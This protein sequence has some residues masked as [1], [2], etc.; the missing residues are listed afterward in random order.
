MIGAAANRDPRA[1][2]DA[3]KFDIDRDRTEAQNLGLG[4]GIH[5]CLGAALCL[6]RRVALRRQMQQV[7]PTAL[8][9]QLQAQSGAHVM[10][11]APSPVAARQARYVEP[12]PAYAPPAPLQSYGGQPQ[13]QQQY[14][15]TPAPPRPAPLQPLQF[16]YAP[17]NSALQY[18][19]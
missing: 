18:R 4:Y 1:F 12:P 19:V 15:Y 6:R 16:G 10:D 13:P 11:Y 17:Y 5:S 9:W 2:T 8:Y 3:H 14:G 7:P